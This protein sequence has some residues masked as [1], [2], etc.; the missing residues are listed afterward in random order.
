MFFGKLFDLPYE[1]FVELI[2]GM[3]LETTVAVLELETDAMAVGAVDLK[4]L[5]R[6]VEIKRTRDDGTKGARA[7]AGDVGL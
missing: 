5:S 2:A 6:F 4:E 3:H 7:R 1:S